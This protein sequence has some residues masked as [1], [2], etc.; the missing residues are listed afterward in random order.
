MGFKKPRDSPQKHN[1]PWTLAKL[2]EASGVDFN[3]IKYNDE[4]VYRMLWDKSVIYDQLTPEQQEAFEKHFDRDG[5]NNGAPEASTTY[6]SGLL[7]KLKIT[8]FAE[9]VT[10]QG[11]SHGK[12]LWKGTQETALDKR[13][14][15]PEEVFG[16]REAVKD[17]LVKGGI[18]EIKAFYIVESL[19]K[20]KKLKQEEVEEVKKCKLNPEVIKNIL[21]IKYLFP[22]NEFWGKVW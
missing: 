20:G 4:K 21:G 15:T 6:V 16:C 5:L 17:F 18:E 13:K 19:R 14:I 12:N 11:I 7:S 9:L 8:T 3:K 10:L 2:R 22:K 1:A